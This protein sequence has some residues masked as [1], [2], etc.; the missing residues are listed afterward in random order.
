MSEFNLGDYVELSEDNGWFDT[1]EG[2]F[3]VALRYPECPGNY[4]YQ[5][6][7]AVSVARA[8]EPL[9]PLWINRSYVKK[10][11]PIWCKEE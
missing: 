5:D 11:H 8:S 9:C 2:P 10:S 3:I 1:K 4:R 7:G 6:H